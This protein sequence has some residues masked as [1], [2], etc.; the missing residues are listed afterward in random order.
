MLK[1][2]RFLPHFVNTDAIPLLVQNPGNAIAGCKVSRQNGHTVW[3][4]GT[5]DRETYTADV[6]LR[7]FYQQVS[8][9][10]QWQCLS[11]WQWV[12]PSYYNCHHHVTL[13]Q[14][15]ENSAIELFSVAG[16]AIWMPARRTWQ[17]AGRTDGR[18]LHD[19][20]SCAMQSSCSRE[21]KQLNIAI[22]QTRRVEF[23]VEFRK[24]DWIK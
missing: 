13:Y 1:S 5:R 19:G 17:T 23:W 10:H 20:V 6:G 8:T 4:S 12:S 14:G 16:R 7:C 11:G 2:V 15:R 24:L 21:A 22:L 3:R 9:L 18:T